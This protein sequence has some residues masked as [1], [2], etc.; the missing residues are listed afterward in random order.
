MKKGFTLVEMIAVI[1]L[2]AV[3]ALIII[4][5]MLNIIS[6]QKDKLYQEQINEIYN[7]TELYLSKETPTTDTLVL[8][9]TTLKTKG[10]LKNEDIIDP[11]DKSI[12]NGD[13]LLVWDSSNNR[14]NYTFYQG[15]Y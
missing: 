11:R 12:I 7:A 6:K 9:L 15:G 3:I 13:I 10:Y 8:S 14:Y 1:A 2:L 5:N 4:P